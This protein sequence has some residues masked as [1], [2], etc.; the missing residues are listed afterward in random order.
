MTRMRSL[1]GERR[2]EERGSSVGDIGFWDIVWYA[3]A[4]I[5]IGALA[6]LILP[7]KQSMGWI[8]TMVIGVVAA[9]VGGLLW[10][11]IF[12]GNEGIAWIGSIIVAVVIIVLYERMVAKKKAS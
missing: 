3:I 12:S 4:G 11:A 1:P 7:G 2:H 5:V 6:R 9:I 8:L 10:N